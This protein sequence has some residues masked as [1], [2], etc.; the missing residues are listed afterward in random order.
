MDA[1]R[2][3]IDSRDGD[4]AGYDIYLD[5]IQ[6]SLDEQ[7]QDLADVE[8][9]LDDYWREPTEQEEFESLYGGMLNEDTMGFYE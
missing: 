9:D 5:S 7:E 4:Y 8:L 1:N 2:V 6:L 3:E